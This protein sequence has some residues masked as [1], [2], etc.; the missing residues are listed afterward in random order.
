MTIAEKLVERHG[1]DYVDRMMEIIRFKREF[2][3]SR[4]GNLTRHFEGL[5]VTVFRRDTGRF[6]YSVSD[7]YGTR[8]SD[9]GYESESEA[10]H[11]LARAMDI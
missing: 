11:A 6:D 10:L 5:S 4:K 1:Q 7:G 2:N 3:R 8:F 9:F